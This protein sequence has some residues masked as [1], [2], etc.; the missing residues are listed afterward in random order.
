MHGKHEI[1]GFGEERGLGRFAD[2]GWH[3]VNGFVCLHGVEL[4]GRS[5]LNDR[6]GLYDTRR[7]L[8][9]PSYCEKG[10]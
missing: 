1:L 6:I 4:L 5:T 2:L 9:A 10:T 7:L 3:E 8:Q